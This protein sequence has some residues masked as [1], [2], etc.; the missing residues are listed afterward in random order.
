M[1]S[2]RYLAFRSST[3]PLVFCCI[4]TWFFD[5]LFVEL[6]HR[7][8]NT[9]VCTHN[10]LQY[11]KQHQWLT[12][13]AAIGQT[14][15]CCK[16]LR[17]N[18]HRELVLLGSNAG[19][20]CLLHLY[21]CQSLFAFLWTTILACALDFSPWLCM[22]IF[23]DNRASFITIASCLLIKIY[24]IERCLYERTLRVHVPGI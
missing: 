20:G 14:I 15:Y 2:H 18:V 1:T 21:I 10:D 8:G 4:A 22:S 3:F 16:R 12:L 5:R 23:L 24:Y 7:R 9:S 11:T 6:G 17:K 13:V 19:P